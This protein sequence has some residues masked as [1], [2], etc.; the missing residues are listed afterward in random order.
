MVAITGCVDKSL[1]AISLSSTA[2][3]GC[4]LVARLSFLVGPNGTGKSTILMALAQ[5]FTNEET[6]L[7]KRF[8]GAGSQVLIDFIDAPPCGIAVLDPGHKIYPNG[9]TWNVVDSRHGMKYIVP[10][11]AQGILHEFRVLSANFRPTEPQFRETK[12]DVVAF[13][14][15]G[16]RSVAPYKLTGIQELTN[17]PLG[18]ALKF[19]SGGNPAHLGTAL[20]LNRHLACELP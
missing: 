5:V 2:D 11:G 3:R 9:V 19:T 17:H 15:N 20:K 4:L 13:A 16:Q 12:F 6:G 18:E 1:W 8:H 14:Y 10:S 7:H